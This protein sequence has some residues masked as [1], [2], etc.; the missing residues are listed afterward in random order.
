MPEQQSLQAEMMTLAALAYTGATTRPSGESVSDQEARILAG[1]NALL[2]DV[3]PDWVATW[4]GL[5]QDRA[6][7]AY[8]A[9]NTTAG[10][11]THVVG[12]RGTVLS[13][14]DIIQDV[15]VTETLPFVVAGAGTTQGEVARGAMEAF[16]E[17][18]MGTSLVGTLLSL[19]DLGTLYVT[20]HSLGGAL[21]T[22]VAPY[23]AGQVG[24]AETVIPFTFAA[25]TV[26]DKAFA[27]SFNGQ[28]PSAQCVVNKY[29]IAPNAWAGLTAIGGGFYPDTS[30]TVLGEIATLVTVVQVTL[31]TLAYEQPSQQPPLNTDFA[32]RV[33]SG[34]F[35]TAEQWFTEAAFQ[36]HTSTYLTLLGVAPLPA[37]EPVVQSLSP[38]AGPAAGHT[39]V[40]VTGTGLTPSSV[41]DFGV[42]AGTNVVFESSTSLRVDAPAGAGVVDVTVTNEAGTSATNANDRFTFSFD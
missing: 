2:P 19:S 9:K 16:T 35:D 10:A 28:F 40:T 29:D 33:T 13:A 27:T 37:A 1:I 42:A 11:I 4:V 20:G 36:H 8:I 21:V 18:V 22:M 30:W 38:A 5:T 3:A 41:V 34:E 17:V 32:V 39:T 14:F 23:L 15:D 12:V 26:G 25:P 31:G 24:V 7:L 6:N